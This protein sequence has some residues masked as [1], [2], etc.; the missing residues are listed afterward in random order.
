MEKAGQL[1]VDFY[2]SDRSIPVLKDSLLDGMRKQ[3]M[4]E[5]YVP[6]D[7]AGALCS[8]TVHK[9]NPPGYFRGYAYSEEMYQDMARSCNGENEEFRKY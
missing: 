2:F 8:C 4:S 3:G 9:R 6:C 7:P 5:R 1:C